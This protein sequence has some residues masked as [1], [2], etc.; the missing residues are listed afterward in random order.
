[1]S[2]VNIMGMVA[3]IKDTTVY[4]ALVEAVNNSIYSIE[5]SGRSDGEIRIDLIR[6]KPKLA[7]S[8]QNED[9]DAS[10]PDITSVYIT[11]N[12]VGFNDDNIG[13]FDEAYT[14][15]KVH[16]G[17]KGFGRF[18]YLKHFTDV[19][20]SSIY[21]DADKFYNRKF[22]L[23]KVN[24]IVFNP[25]VTD[26]TATDSLTL[27][28]LL[29]IRDGYIDK[30]L[31]TITRKLLEK[32][33]VQFVR[34]DFVCPKII[35]NDDYMGSSV[36]LNEL[37]ADTKYSEI[38]PLGDNKFEIQA[39]N[40]NYEFLTHMFKIWFPGNQNSKISLASNYLEVTEAP[41]DDYINEF[42]SG[43]S[44]DFEN[45]HGEKSNRFIIKVYVTG[46]YL[47]DN[48]DRE[49]V[50]FQFGKKGDSL[51][52]IGKTEIESNAADIVKKKFL[53]T[54]TTERTKK[55]EKASAITE[56]KPWLRQH[57]NALDLSTLRVNSSEEDYE[58]ALEMIRIRKDRELSLT[59]ESLAKSDAKKLTDDKTEEIIRNITESNKNDLARYVARRKAVLDIFT[60]SLRSKEEDGK[61]EM[62]KVVHDIIYPMQSDSDAVGSQYQNLWL[63]DERLNFT[64]FIASDKR[65]ADDNSSRPDLF[66]FHHQVAFRA[67]DEKQNPIT[68]V[69]FKRP[70]R[71][72][73]ASR[74]AKENPVSQ[75]IR[76]TNDIRDGQYKKPGDR[77]IHTDKDTQFYGYVIVDFSE[78]VK[79]WLREEENF[80]AMPD[81]LG[82]YKWME[83]ISLY[84]EVL[85]WDKVLK[86]A[87]IRN[88]IFSDKLG[89]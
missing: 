83:N 72:D 55:E 66:V 69:E 48:V 18:V 56:E 51:H 9:S 46:K 42:E 11:D 39:G 19:H 54:F 25:T 3:T 8:V 37:L 75:I 15:H 63:L 17:G 74:T 53:A 84:L 1:M 64:E 87:Q 43:F 59:A 33:L 76:Y 5:S 68:L 67:G 29:N 7:L 79:T 89:L 78:K 20:I 85:S 16:V 32:I 34:P 58:V 82:Y 80:T 86:D 2:Q 57:Q 4:T 13:G 70:G 28:E 49:R 24:D 38:Q 62:E 44:G 41:L 23:G 45:S 22:E 30:R 36:I 73:F 61:H 31:D 81:G 6:D 60:A 88:R 35:V 40:D 14:R 65:M 52:P 47:D 50:S 71:D 77:P 12:G 10:L 26:S 27:V 21:K